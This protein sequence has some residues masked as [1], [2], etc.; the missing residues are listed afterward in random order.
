[1][2]PTTKSVVF[3]P[4]F[5][6]LPDYFNLWLH[7]CSYHESF[8]FIIFTDDDTEARS[9]KNDAHRSAPQSCT[10]SLHRPAP[11]SLR[12]RGPTPTSQRGKGGSQRAGSSSRA[13]VS[14]WESWDS[15]LG[16]AGPPKPAPPP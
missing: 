7:S 3:V 6:K 15:S 8:S 13:R 5:G 11:T 2:Q 14:V 16:P 10:P 12:A 9:G 1:M 4:F